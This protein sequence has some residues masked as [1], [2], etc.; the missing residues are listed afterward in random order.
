VGNKQLHAVESL[1]VQ[2]MA[3]RLKTIGWP[4]ARDVE[5]WLVESN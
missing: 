3:H 2:V 4:E 1:L 5:N